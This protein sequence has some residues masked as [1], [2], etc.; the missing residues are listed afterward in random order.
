[1]STK[2]TPEEIREARK[3]AGLT[4]KQAGA[5]VHATDRAWRYWEAGE[6]DMS[7]LAWEQFQTK[8]ETKRVEQ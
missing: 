3:R 1:M 5:L 7:P 2:P 4:Q 8:T 6:R